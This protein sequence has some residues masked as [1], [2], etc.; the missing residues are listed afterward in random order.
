MGET[1]PIFSTTFNRCAQIEA[2]ADH[3]SADTGALLVREIMERTGIVE[4]MTERLIDARNPHLITY[5][6]ADLLRT[7]LL[8]L[9]QGWRDQDDTDRLRHD[10]SFR[11]ANDSRRGTASLEQESVLPSQP[12]LSR[13][14]DALSG[15][16]NQE[17]V[18][19]A[20]IELALRRLEMSNK[21]RRRKRLM[22]DV[23]GLPA[24]VH[25]QQAG[26]E[27]NGYYGQRMFHALIASCAES[28]DLLA[29]T[30]RPG[31]VGSADGALEFIQ[32]VVER[33]RR[34]CESVLLRI[35]AG[36]AD[37]RTLTGLESSGIDYV[38]R[39]CATTRCAGPHGRAVSAPSAGASAARGTG[40]VSRAALPGR[41]VGAPAAGGAGG[42]G[43][44]GRVVRRSLLVDHQPEARPLQRRAAA[45]A[46]P[47][48]GQGRGAHG[49]ADGRVGAGVLV[50]GPVRRATTG[51]AAW[52]LTAAPRNQGCERRT[53][54][55]CC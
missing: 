34:V 18:R 2:R 26:S 33:V 5:P 48:A 55:C 21:G 23:D 20:V 12:T 15:D 31:A 30:L 46:V 9:G 8:L 52:R 7:N 22:V 38:A 47:H 16:A 3:L 6:L 25:G 42:V 4:W 45:G 32:A 11:V 14:L 27:Y 49:G 44:A 28:G 19:E 10:P 35:D 37:G 13:L 50:V 24:E 29:G 40:V 53:R 36:F 54:R 41:L 17:V 39:A 1:L 43:A 51:A